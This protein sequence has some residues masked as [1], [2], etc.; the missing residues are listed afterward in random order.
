MF[1]RPV[2]YR[3]GNSLSWEAF[4]QDDVRTYSELD[5]ERS[6]FNEYSPVS[7]EI[8]PA[9]RVRGI[10]IRVATAA[11]F[12]DV[13]VRLARMY[14]THDPAALQKAEREA[15][16]RRPARPDGHPRVSHDQN[17]LHV[18]RGDSTLR[19]PATCPSSTCGEGAVSLKSLIDDLLTLAKKGYAVVDRHDFT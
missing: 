6:Q 13:A 17:P 12:V 1:D 19:E 18:S 14:A 11:A 2:T 4:E 9:R 3:P 7:S 5:D 15:R 10:N 16:P 8:I